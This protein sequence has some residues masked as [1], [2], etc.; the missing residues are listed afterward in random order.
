MLVIGRGVV[1]G[2]IHT[3][4]WCLMKTVFHWLRALSCWVICLLGTTIGAGA[5]EPSHFHPDDGH[6]AGVVVEISGG[7]A[8]IVSEGLASRALKI[9]D[10]IVDGDELSTGAG[11]TV[12]VLWDHR[13]LLTLQAQARLKIQEPHRGQTD[14]QLRRGSMRIA[15]SY[16]A[17]R[18]TDKLTLQTAFARVVSRGGIFEAS[19]VKADQ[20]PLFARMMNAPS[21]DTFRVLEGQ[22][23]IEPLS[24]EGKPFSIKAGSE[25]S[26]TAGTA[27]AISETSTRTSGPQ[28]LAAKTEHRESP[29]SITRQIIH[30]HVGLALESEK[31][32]ERIAT[33]GN[34]VEQ[35]GSTTKGVILATS[36]GVPSFPSVQAFGSGSAS[37]TSTASVSSATVP[38]P[39][40]SVSV[41]GA[42]AA[43]GSAQSGGLNS[44]GLLKQLLNE[45]GR[46]A[47]GKDKK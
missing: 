45:V 11:A 17:G 9:G 43:I 4:G 29:V 15:L 27:P 10:R 7:S 47:K 36:T 26:L 28:P 6:P 40:G 30:A 21:V 38:P 39:A 13:A 31:E 22:A 46:G 8:S 25:A 24:G 18:M 42:G 2:Q 14:L 41:S 34:E 37:G 1:P 23:R 19:V 35:P 5:E 16:N 33:G 20:R 3:N 32:L 12:D 44:S